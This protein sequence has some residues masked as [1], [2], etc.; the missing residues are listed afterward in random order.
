MEERFNHRVLPVNKTAGVSTYDCIRRFKRVFCIDKVGHAGSLDPPARGLILL[1]TGEATKLSNYLMDLPKRYIADIGLGEATDTH[2][3]SGKVVRTGSWD[4]LREEDI[5]SVLPM[6]LGKRLQI[7]PMY[8]ALK[9]RGTPLYMLARKGQKVDRSPREIE[10]YEIKLVW[11]RLPVFRIEV[12]CSR[13]LYIRVLAEEIGEALNVPSHLSGLVRTNVGHFDLESAVPDDAF[14]TLLDMDDPGYS[15][16][17]A[18]K[19]LPEIILSG[20]QARKLHDGIA[21]R[22]VPQ[23]EAALPPLGSLVRLVRPDGSLGAIGEVGMAGFLQ[24]KRVFRTTDGWKRG[25]AR[26]RL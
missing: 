2:D 12:Y 5:S 16:S 15:L 6:F 21:P 23:A 9:H 19:H 10:T 26:G 14:E 1:L 18:L 22:A 11:C 20:D 7:P 25:D 17:G 24:I 4:H 3:A 8:S 13:G